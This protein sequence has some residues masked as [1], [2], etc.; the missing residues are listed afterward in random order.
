L[1][2]FIH[3]VV[4]LIKSNSSTHFLFGLL[5]EVVL[6][7]LVGDGKPEPVVSKDEKDNLH[8]I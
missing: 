1:S 7:V 6:D 4:D 2:F 5:I 3:T 8:F